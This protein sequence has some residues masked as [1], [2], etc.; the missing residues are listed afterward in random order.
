MPSA[1][2]LLNC[3]LIYKGRID[4]KEKHMVGFKY[5]DYCVDSLGEVV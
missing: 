1:S 3:L 4:T 2:S 5:N